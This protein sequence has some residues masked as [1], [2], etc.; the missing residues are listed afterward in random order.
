MSNIHMNREECSILGW[1]KKG[2]VTKTTT[3][4]DVYLD[5]RVLLL[6]IFREWNTVKECQFV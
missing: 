1:P 6:H 3:F 2:C 5:S 4:D